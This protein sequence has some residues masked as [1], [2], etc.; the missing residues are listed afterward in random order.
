[1]RTAL[2]VD[3]DPSV[4]KLFTSALEIDGWVVWQAADGRKALDVM[5]SNTPDVVMLDM[6]M[7]QMSGRSVLQEM[8]RDERLRQ[9][10]TVV[11]SATDDPVERRLALDLGA[12]AWLVKPVSVD[13]FLAAAWDY[14][15][16]ESSFDRTPAAG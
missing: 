10:P 2:V 8:L 3:D 16:D 15:S 12:V 7:P 1:M 13:R 11:V 9:I 5:A 4:R 6:M 14:R